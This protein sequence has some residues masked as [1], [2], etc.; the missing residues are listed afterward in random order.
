MTPRDN[1]SNLR[2]E[3]RE[4]KL[5][6]TRMR[7]RLND[8][9]KGHENMKQDLQ[10]SNSKKLVSSITKKFGNLSWFRDRSPFRASASASECS[11]SFV[12]KHTPIS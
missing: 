7:M 8:L 12:S 5:E 11:K 9:E 2:R 1:Y 10:K 6:L 3:N 4:L